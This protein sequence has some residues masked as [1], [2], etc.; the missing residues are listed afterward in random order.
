MG[1]SGV[2]VERRA[3]QLNSPQLMPSTGSSRSCAVLMS[4]RRQPLATILR[5]LWALSGKK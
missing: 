4:K 1:A 5:Q 3:K 2:K